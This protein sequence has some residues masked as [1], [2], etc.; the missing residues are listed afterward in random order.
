MSYTYWNHTACSF[1]KCTTLLI[2]R[3]LKQEW[4]INKSVYIYITTCIVTHNK[5]TLLASPPFPV[6]VTTNTMT[7]TFLGENLYWPSLFPSY[8]RGGK[9]FTCTSH[10]FF[11]RWIGASQWRGWQ[12]G[13]LLVG[14]VRNWNRPVETPKSVAKPEANHPKKDLRIWG[15]GS[16]FQFQ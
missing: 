10:A 7:I 4:W 3:T 8:L 6:I 13:F 11:Q 12:G 9:H 2:L 14:T 1:H 5:L 16:V 15:K